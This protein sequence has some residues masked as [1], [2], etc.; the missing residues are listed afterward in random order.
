M[1]KNEDKNLCY[2]EHPKLGEDLWPGI[3]FCCCYNYYMDFLIKYA[4]HQ[5]ASYSGKPADMWSLGVLLY[6]ML[7]GRYPFYDTT[8]VGLFLK[9]RSAQ[10]GVPLTSSEVPYELRCTVRFLLR[11]DP[12]ERLSAIQLLRLPCILN[13]NSA[14]YSQR[15]KSNILTN[16]DG[17]ED[18]HVVP[19]L[20]PKFRPIVSKKF[21]RQRSQDQDLDFL[22]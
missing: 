21:D 15:L 12:D 5:H 22:S 10:F 7:V 2:E 9:I 11:K 19:D 1:S 13:I 8:P 18:D 16:M 6:V 20:A 14:N 17:K 3:V 4:Q